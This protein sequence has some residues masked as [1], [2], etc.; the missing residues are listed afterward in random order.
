M[1]TDFS[2]LS[3]VDPSRLAYEDW[4]RVGMAIQQEGGTVHDW[5]AWSRRDA[6][7]YKQGECER[8][9]AGFRGS[10]TPITWGTVVAL[11]KAQGYRPP[12]K[13][14]GR[15]YTWDEGPIYGVDEG[16]EFKV[17]DPNWV[18]NIDVAIPDD[19]TWDPVNDV[20]TYLETL[21]ESHEHVSYVAECWR[22][23]D[24]RFSPKP[25]PSDRTAGQ[26]IEE[27]ARC[28]GDLGAVFGDHDP[29]AGAW[30]R[31]NPMDGQGCKD[32]NITAYRYALI[33]SDVIEVERQAA[34][35]AE[36]EL[37]IA[38]LVH[39]GGKSLHAIVRIGATSREEYR[40]RV[41]FLHKVCNKNGLAVDGNNK[42]P[43]RLSRMPGILRNG[44]KQYLV[45]TNQGKPSWEAWEEWIEELNDNLPDIEALADLYADPPPLAAPLIDGLLRQ[46][47]KLLLAGPSKA[48]KSFL[49]LQL[50]IALAE[51]R[52]WLGWR[53][54]QGRVLYVNLELDRA[55][56][57]HRLKT[58][59][60]AR[61]WWPSNIANID[62][63]HLRG[64]AVP[65]DL[66]APKLI[67]RALKSNYVAV[68]I[69]PI[70]KVIT[71]DENAADKMAH[72]CNQFDKVCHDLGC[73]VIYCHHHSKGAQG[74]KS[75]QDRA[76]G[77]G[78]F[79]RDPDAIV[80]L[81][82]L[83]L[84]DKARKTM[85][86]R[87]VCNALSAELDEV[88]EMWSEGI[89]Q[90]DAL[91]VG[92]LTAHAERFMSKQKVAEIRALAEERTA[93][94]SA[95]RLEG[96]LREFPPFNAKGCFFRYP[97]HVEDS[98]GMLKDAKADGEY[99]ERSTEKKMTSKE[100]IDKAFDTL[101]P[102]S[103]DGSVS[104]EDIGYTHGVE[105]STVKKWAKFCTKYYAL[106]SDGMMR[107]IKNHNR[108]LLVDEFDA[109]TDTEGLMRIADIA[110][111]L[112]HKD[113]WVRK[114][115]ADWG[116]DCPF[117]VGNGFMRRK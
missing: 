10:A 114:Q 60:E 89:S 79:A 19:T 84:D 67:R 54:A 107:R 37:P 23:E 9:W 112:K 65:M 63:W 115:L 75:A 105:P 35:Y 42:N 72:F 27:L 92:P 82:E 96:T 39:S 87:A 16:D 41:E 106:G 69:D 29:E 33:E 11:A 76:S 38:A 12:P 58:L 1:S 117:V 26:L 52:D 28:R 47:H 53:C 17:Y 2:I 51:G 57:L 90:D 104:L 50:T 46:G 6:A 71:G 113:D 49:L 80:D 68:I 101:E 4:L 88:S 64:K 66:L 73:A 93:K 20:V 40:K 22:G 5:E 102:F 45:A 15:A 36:L 62:V 116:E 81:I 100:K 78:V 34:I 59:Y 13:D 83:N 85:A 108:K 56:C 18:E 31:F 25:G 21:F 30:I 86:D 110:G 55:S 24:G 74:G 14:E 70:Y 3:H 61:G 94:W 8:K 109:H 111:R 77:S 97:I 99:P 32:A 7:R 95:W 48:G 91:V 98:D 43:S 103:D 44:K